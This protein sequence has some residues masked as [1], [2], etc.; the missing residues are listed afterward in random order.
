MPRRDFLED[1][2]QAPPAVLPSLL[3][4]DF[5]NLAAE[6]HALQAAG[7]RALHLDVMD[8]NFVPNL[9]YGMTIVEAVR[10]ST[11]L[12]LE[13]HLMIARPADYVDAFIDAGADVVTIHA[14]AVDDPRPVL[15]QIRRR[16]AAAGLAINPPTPVET[17]AAALPLCDVVLAMSV[18]PGFG[19]QAF[20]PVALNKLRALRRQ[21]GDSLLL[22]VDGGVN[23]KTVAECARAGA[24]LLVVGSAIFRR[25][26]RPYPE[27]IAEL[28][29]LA[30]AS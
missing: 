20:D 14:E 7:A 6:V 18:M 10:K 29:E 9:T 28:T 11:D 2:R 27:S 19:S 23:E 13:A 15:E 8:G 25:G 12:P 3:L 1:F 30:R 4:C 22:E 21:W 17:I 24:Q 26:G 16:G 5:G